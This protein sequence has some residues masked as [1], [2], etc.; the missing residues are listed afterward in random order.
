MRMMRHW[1]ELPREAVDAPSLK[2]IKARLD[3]SLS[4]RKV[5]LPMAVVLELDDL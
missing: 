5:F 3:G 4:R 1:N 2:V